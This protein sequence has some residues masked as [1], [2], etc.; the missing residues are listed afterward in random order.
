VSRRSRGQFD[1]EDRT[2]LHRD[3]LDRLYTEAHLPAREVAARTATSTGIVLRNAHDLG[4]P[5]RVGG[6]PPRG[7]PAEIA[8]VDAL[9]ADPLVAAV[10][11]RHD[12]PFRP[13]GGQLWQRFPDRVPLTRAVLSDLYGE[14][15]VAV[16]HI[17]MLTGQPAVTVLRSL[18]A[19]GTAMRPPG[20]RSPFL[21]RWRERQRRGASGSSGSGAPGSSGRHKPRRLR[22]V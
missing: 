12:L 19:N 7:G 22:T 21:Q 1:R 5:V 20:G 6:P 8:L 14:A 13:A 3:V 16:Q 11:A 4:I 2:P 10:V 18:R 17:E 15:G 9:Y